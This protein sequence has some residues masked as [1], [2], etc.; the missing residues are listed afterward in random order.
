MAVLESAEQQYPV[1]LKNNNNNK[2]RENNNWTTIL[3]KY[4]ITMLTYTRK[5]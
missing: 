3:Y 2:M 1:G 4:T 5:R